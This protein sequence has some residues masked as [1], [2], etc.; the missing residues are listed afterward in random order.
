VAEAHR[1][2]CKMVQET[3]E[4]I[5]VKRPAPP[6]TTPQGI[7]LDTGDD[8]DEIREWLAEFGCTAHIGAWG[9]EANALQQDAGCRAGGGSWNARIVGG[10]ASGAC[11][12]AGTRTCAPIWGFCIWS[13]LMSRIDKLAYWDSL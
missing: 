2:D 7:C 8:D 1:H 6:P 10:I 3:L 11:C 13:V 5:P 9:E 4:S 12:S